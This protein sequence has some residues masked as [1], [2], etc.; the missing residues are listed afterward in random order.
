MHDPGVLPHEFPEDEID[1][2][3]EK[4]YAPTEIADG[5]VTVWTHVDSCRGVV[6]RS[7][8]GANRAWIVL[9]MTHSIR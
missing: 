1:R 6:K 8:S 3:F 5:E 9:P 7:T 4:A 2:W